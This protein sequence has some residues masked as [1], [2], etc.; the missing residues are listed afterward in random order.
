M[1][2]S[3]SPLSSKKEKRT[4]SWE[5]RKLTDCVRIST[6]YPFASSD[7]RDEGQYLVITN[8]NIQANQPS[9]LCD[10]GNH[11]TP[12]SKAIEKE[13]VLTEN[14]ILVTMDGEV[15][16]AAKVN[17]SRMILA[18]RV[19][20]LT[21]ERGREFYYQLISSTRFF[22]TMSDLAHGGTIKHISLSEI[23][24]YMFRMP[25]EEKE[26]DSIAYLLVRI[27]SL[28]TLHQREGKYSP[29]RGEKNEKKK[30]CPFCRLL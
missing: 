19:A 28:I 1:P 20:R 10:I 6:G 25:M 7:F 3:Y 14:D 27:D 23:G 17:Y 12:S 21:V 26:S 22:R 30:K 2:L 15:G 18:Q 13:Y 24:S 4:Y 11:I 9:V 29:K 16:R 5:Q 8:G